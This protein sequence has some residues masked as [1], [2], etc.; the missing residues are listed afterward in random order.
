MATTMAT[1]IIS[2]ARKGLRH[3]HWRPRWRPQTNE[4]TI[5]MKPQEG[6]HAYVGTLP[7]RIVGRHTGLDKGVVHGT[8]VP[9]VR[10][11]DECATIV[12]NAIALDGKT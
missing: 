1:I 9:R 3:D 8:M 7:T 4:S 6:K 5:C 11:P 10:A 2:L 12:R